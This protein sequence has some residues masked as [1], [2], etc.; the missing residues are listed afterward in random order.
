VK[1]AVHQFVPRFEPGA[2]GTALVQGRDALRAAGHSSDIFADEIDVRWRALG[3]RSPGE[4][5]S[6]ADDVAVYHLAIGAAMADRLQQHAGR[7]VVAYHNL[8]P[9]SLLE[10]WDPALGPAVAWGR[11]QLREL[12]LRAVLGIGMSTFSEREL[13]D[14]GFSQTAT[15][16]VLFDADTLARPAPDLLSRL[17]ATKAGSDWLFVS[18]IAPNK[19][20]H[21]VVRAFAM[22]RHSHDPAARL[23]LPGASASDTYFAALRGYVEAL[24]LSGAVELPGE[25]P[26]ESLAAYFAAADVFVCL[27]DHEGFGVPLLEA[28]GHDVPVVAFGRAAVPETA[29]DAALVLPEKSAGTV[30]S[31]VARVLVDERL[32]NRLVDR[33][34]RRLATEFDNERVRARFVAAIESVA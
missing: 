33:G 24:G 13:V 1:R 10:P 9:A 3:A 20:Q 17:V 4:Y 25:V 6:S 26:P 19:A 27:S 22:F 8:T 28:W 31:A 32:R 29:G 15:V 16:P 30:A 18:R 14:A 34:R 11:T 5:R 21:D 23:W 12:A 2:V 7:L